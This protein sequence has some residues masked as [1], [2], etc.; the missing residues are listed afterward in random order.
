MSSTT[1]FTL[2]DWCA[3]A[4]GKPDDAAWRAWA[5]LS[6]S[7]PLWVPGAPL[8]ETK[9][10]PMMTARRMS[11]GT[12]LAVQA[13]LALAQR[14]ADIGAAVFSS[15]HGEIEHLVQNLERQAVGVAPS[16]ADFATSVHN[17][18]VGT[19]SIAAQLPLPSTSVAAG[20]ASFQQALYEVRAFFAAGYETVLLV[21]F[22]NM[23]PEIYRAGAAHF[24]APYAA[25][26]VLGERAGEQ[27]EQEAPEEREAPDRTYRAYK[28]YKTYMPAAAPD[29]P[30]ADAIPPSLAFLR[31]FLRAATAAPPQ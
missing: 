6:D 9:L 17:T 15:Q 20:K 27:E 19:F 22:E 28:S 23:L 16:P 11:T 13:A 2:L 3:L 30:A 25:A 18:A 29:S 14:H 1:H 21:D 8:P 31:S 24:P 10:L 5:A 12:R 7:A 4:P 26:F